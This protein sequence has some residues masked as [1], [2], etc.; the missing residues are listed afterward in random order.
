MPASVDITIPVFNEERD[1]PDSIAKL[2]EFLADHLANPWRI[3]IADNASTDSTGSV[4][5]ELCRQFP[6]VN[7]LHIPKKGRGLALR[8]A[9]L[10]SSADIVSYMDV[11][12]STDIAHF[13]QM[14]SALESG[15]HIAVG[16]RLS[17][18]SQVT[19]GIKREFISRTY[20]LIIRGMF[21][22]S[23]PDAQCGFKAL[24]R[25]AAQAILPHV[26]NNNWFYDTEL[27]IIA[28]KNGYRIKS[29]PVKWDDDPASSVSLVGTAAED[30]R[31]LFRL[32]FGGVARI[33]SPTSG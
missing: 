28:A 21:W 30:L 26:E 4:A 6:S 25:E 5:Q 9:W 32:R 3:T 20:N 11:D 31:G 10:Q 22:T 19:R 12:L 14:V 29:V 7:Y 23:F 33:S 8:T 27:L 2:T 15:Y 13:P 18:E 17:R 16:S 24:T 1:L